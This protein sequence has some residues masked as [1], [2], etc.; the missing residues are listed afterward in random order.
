[1][2]TAPRSLPVTSYAWIVALIAGLGLWATEGLAFAGSPGAWQ[3]AVAAGL[4]TFAVSTFRDDWRFL[5]P[6]VH[7][8]AR[9]H[10]SIAIGVFVG[11]I[12]Y[13]GLVAWMQHRDLRPAVADEYGYLISARM[14]SHG[15][16]WMPEHPLGDFFESYQMIV[17]GSYACAYF[18]GTAVFLV[19]A[20][21]LGLPAWAVMLPIAGAI[22]ALL[23]LIFTELFDGASALLVV[24]MTLSTGTAQ[25]LWAC[26]RAG[27]RSPGRSTRCVTSCPWGSRS[28]GTCGVVVPAGS[29]R[30]SHAAWSASRRS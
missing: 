10:R 2:P 23:Y 28:C 22:V 29:R 24:V 19:P 16:L 7:P 14:L 4:V 9:T 13:L 12:A 18:P 11:S 5:E 1:M 30:P 27:P 25:S 21:W 8:S 15:R 20:V 6:I 17:R 3:T 26:S